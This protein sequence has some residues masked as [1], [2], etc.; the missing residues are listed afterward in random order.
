MAWLDPVG[1]GQEPVADRVC[2]GRLAQALVP[3]G[4]RELARDD[5][6]PDARPVLDDLEQVGG[7]SVDERLQGGACQAG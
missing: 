1:G 5:R 2:H 7:L 6:A 4:D 3:Q